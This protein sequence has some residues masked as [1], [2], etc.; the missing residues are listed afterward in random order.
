MNNL[1]EML[2]SEMLMS[3]F[4]VFIHCFIAFYCCLIVL[5]AFKAQGRGGSPESWG[6]PEE[7]LEE[8]PK[9]IPK[10]IPR[11]TPKEIPKEIHRGIVRKS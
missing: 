9:E 10:E 8:I 11:E 3:V 6:N 4:N 1:K 7:I 2:F 5:K